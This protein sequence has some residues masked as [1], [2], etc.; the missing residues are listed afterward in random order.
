MLLSPLTSLT[1]PLVLRER[2]RFI[3]VAAAAPAVLLLGHLLPATGPGLAVR[4]AGAAA[5][6]VILPG[7]LILRALAWPSS[8]GI[9][10]AASFA[11]SLVVV[12]FALALVFAV[13]ASI[14]LAAGVIVIVSACAAVPA[15]LRG[16]S[17]PVPRRERWAV[18]AVLVAA[19]G[20]AGIVWWSAG[21]LA[22]DAFFHLARARKLAEFDS[23]STL[24]TVGEFDNGE[25]HPGYAFPLLHAV[26]A[27]V[28]RFAGVD[29][30]VAFLYLPAILVPLAFVIAYGAGWAVFRSRAGGLALVAAQTALFGFSGFIRGDGN[31]PGT[32]LFEHLTQPQQAS[33]VLLITAVLA[34]AFAFSVEGGW[35]LLAALGAAAL[36][37]TAVHPTYAPYLALVLAAFLLARALFIR[38]W[39]PLVTRATLAVGVVIASFGLFLILLLPVARDSYGFTPSSGTRAA[40]LEHYGKAFTTLRGWVGLS[41]D[42]VARF[43]PL[44][45]A[46]LLAFPLAAFATR[47]LW[48]ALVLGGSLTILAVVLVPPLFTALS[49]AFS[50]SQGRR[51]P[52]FLPI[53]FALV[54]G[55]L[56]VSRLKALG[57]GIAAGAGIA[58]VLLYPGETGNRHEQAGPGWAVW[59][60]VA[61]GLLAVAAGILLRP[62]GPNPSMWAAGAT[63]AFVVPLAVTGLSEVTHSSDKGALP[64]PIIAAVRA[65]TAPGDV[66]FSDPRTAYKIAAS[67]AV[68]INASTPDHVADTRRNAPGR[69]SAAARHFFADRSLTDGERRAILDRYHADWVLVDKRQ[70][71]PEE[72]LRLLRLVY[73]GR[74]YELYEVSS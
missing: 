32:G 25:L 8:L 7:A 3:A 5:C 63:V 15:V 56:V 43:G 31:P 40:E 36:A 30:T 26:D 73:E 57:V 16:R 23:L 2:S 44:I 50:I 69:R 62:E 35:I 13:G 41:P 51:L 19:V 52:Q 10:L 66:V 6:I 39:E 46:G 11:F 28:A 53:A 65:N 71:S 68:Y 47:R 55:C 21:P 60:A 49:D 72:F 12:A 38:G 42:T 67:A 45:V 61:G 22:D 70:P 9:A 34:L 33:H 48:A 17:N 18:G 64:R 24:G 74:R 14:V 27:L 59:L 20:Y 37:L 4:L 54:G 58:L 29:V 1:A